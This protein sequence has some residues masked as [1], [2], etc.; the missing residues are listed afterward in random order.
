ML[1]YEECLEMSD[2][3]SDDISAIAEH[4]HMDPM[5]AVALGHYLITHDGEQRIQRFI[6]DDIERAKR[7][8]DRNKQ[9]LLYG[10]LR[11]FVANH[12]QHASSTRLQ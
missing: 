8:G 2:L 10:A 4:E 1:T 5:I 12:P 6:L 7:C 3:T 9:A 11:H